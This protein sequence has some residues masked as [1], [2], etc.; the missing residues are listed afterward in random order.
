MVV[1]DLKAKTLV[2]ILR[3]N[4]AKDATVYTDEASQYHGLAK[5]FAVHDTSVTALENTFVARFTPT[6]SKAISA[7]LNAA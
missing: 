2:P 3:E 4:I 7:S 1:E 6:L 5:N